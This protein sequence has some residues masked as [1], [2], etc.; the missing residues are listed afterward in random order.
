MITRTDAVHLMGL[1]TQD[2]VL[3]QRLNEIDDYIKKAC[4]EKKDEIKVCVHGWNFKVVDA[5]KQSLAHRDFYVKNDDY[6]MITI[7]W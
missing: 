6:T 1:Q 3:Q 4:E 5:I 7:E 2:D